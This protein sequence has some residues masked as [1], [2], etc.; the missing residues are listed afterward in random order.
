MIEK[1]R[2]TKWKCPKCNDEF[3]TDS[4]ARW[5]MKSCKEGCTS[6]DAEEHYIRFIGNKPIVVGESDDLESLK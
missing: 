4:K 2:Y 3:I 6:V 1:R 5:Q